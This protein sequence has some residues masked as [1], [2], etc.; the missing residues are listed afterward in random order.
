MLTR[1]S[2][3]SSL[4]DTLAPPTIAATGRFGLPSAASSASSSFCIA[5]PAWR[6]QLVSEPLGRRMRAMGGGEGVIDV[7]VAELGELVDM[8]R[9]VLLFA[10]MEAGVLQQEHVAVL[11]FGDRVVGRLA[12]AV[13]REGDRTLDDVGDRGG[14]GLQRIGLVRAALGPAEMREQNDLAALVRDLG[15]GRRNALDARRVG[16]AA[17]L[18]RHVEIDA[19]QHALAGDVG[20]IE[21]AERFGHGSAPHKL[22]AAATRSSFRSVMPAEAGIQSGRAGQAGLSRRDLNPRF[23]GGHRILR[24]A[25]PSR[26]RC[27][28][29]GSRSPIRCRTRR[30]R[31]RNCRRSPWSDRDGRS[32]SGR[33]G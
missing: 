18:R 7:D 31:G 1:F 17:V 5:R 3:S 16:H 12:D 8:G 6:G 25:S 4:V 14:D 20:V 21:R 13:G 24:S 19:Q 29:C 9:I 2:S 10:L 27:R 22:P 23:R 33:R 30:A 26:R 28:P 15:D 11:H 32:R